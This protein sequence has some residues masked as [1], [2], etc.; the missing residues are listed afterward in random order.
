MTVALSGKEIA[1][2]LEKQFPGSVI[3]S[4]EES[5]LIKPESLPD[6]AS[7]LKTTPEFNF[8]YLTT[9]T[10]VD[11]R[12]YFEVVYILTSLEHNHSLK[13]KARCH[14]RK[15]PSLPSVFSLWRAADLQEREIFDL[16]GIKFD[17]HPNLKRIVLW[18]GFP[19]HPLRKDWQGGD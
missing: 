12:D 8:N 9:I 4:S 3:E 6:L 16:F 19:G 17:G 7:F 13:L 14:D 15:N 2:K 18:E 10:A 1:A 11:Y 5:L